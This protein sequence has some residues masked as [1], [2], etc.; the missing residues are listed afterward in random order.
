MTKLY[1]T[2]DN[3]QKAAYKVNL[4]VTEHGLTNICR[5]NLTDGI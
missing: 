3:L 5:E 2:E 4:V 1:S